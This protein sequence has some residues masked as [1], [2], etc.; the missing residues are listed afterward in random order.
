VDIV[1][2][3]ELNVDLVLTGLSSL[4][5]YGEG[6]LA[7]DMRFTL[8]SSSAIFASNASRL[9]AKVGFIGKAGVDEFGE[10]TLRSLEQSGVDVSQVVKDSFGRTGICVLLSFPHE[11]AMIAYPGVRETFSLADVD[12]D[13]VKAARHLHLSSYYLKPALR[14]DCRTL[15][16]RAKELGLSTSL[17][18]DYDPD[19][20]WDE[21][22][23]L[24]PWVD[25]FL[26]N[27][28]EAT[29]IAGAADVESACAHWRDLPTVNVIKRGANGVLT[30]AGNRVIASPAFAVHPIDTTG[31]GDSFDAGFLYKYIQGAPLAECVTW[32]SAC[33]AL[34]T[35]ALGGTAA[36]PTPEELDQF[37]AERNDEAERLRSA[38][39][40]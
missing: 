21:I 27:E 38:F 39:L 5:A 26:P 4:P 29:R 18:P 16:Q 23:E 33:G 12:F 1:V 40:V 24:L 25:V 34:S 20:K 36:F 14:P 11:Y 17:D 28:Y 19:G 7:R 13:Y 31:A 3:G 30:A 32:G 15:F 22:Q 8:G 37:L 6:R 10:F 9:G 2:V 35:L